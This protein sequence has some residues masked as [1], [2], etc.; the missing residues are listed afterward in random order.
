MPGN[1]VD[2]DAGG[3]V[4]RITATFHYPLHERIFGRLKPKAAEWHAGAPS[5]LPDPLA[6]D[7]AVEHGIGDGGMTL[8]RRHFG[9]LHH[10]GIG[11]GRDIRVIGIDR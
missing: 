2:H 6:F 3:G 7:P 1:L 11:S 9:S 10:G 4:G 8:R 5:H